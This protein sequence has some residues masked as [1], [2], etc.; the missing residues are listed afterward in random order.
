MYLGQ[1]HPKKIEFQ[2]D[3]FFPSNVASVRGK[4]LSIQV[5][6]L[7]TSEFLSLSEDVGVPPMNKESFNDIHGYIIPMYIIE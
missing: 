5:L 7:V 3:C 6:R 4:C 2:F 1:I